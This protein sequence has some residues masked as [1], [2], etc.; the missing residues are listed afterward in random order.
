M[1][2]GIFG[3]YIFINAVCSLC[4]VRSVNCNEVAV[5]MATTIYV[6]NTLR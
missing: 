6:H 5:A 3:V 1:C 4:L 2:G